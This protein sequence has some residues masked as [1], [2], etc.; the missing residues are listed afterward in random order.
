MAA[1]KKKTTKRKTTN[2]NKKSN[3]G[4][5]QSY[6]FKMCASLCV[7]AISVIAL[8]KL[9]IVGNFCFQFFSYFFG[10]VVYAVL[11][12]M[13][14][15]CLYVIIKKDISLIPKK[16]IFGLIFLLLGW[17]TL[18][19]II[20]T[21]PDP[22]W[23]NFSNVFENTFEILFDSMPVR[24]G[25]IGGLLLG[26]FGSLF[27]Y[28][29][30]YLVVGLFFVL[31]I[32]LFGYDYFI[33]REKK[34]KPKQKEK[35]KETKIE[36]VPIHEGKTDSVFVDVDN[37]FIDLEENKPSFQII[38]AD[39]PKPKKK[40]TSKKRA[41]KPKKEEKSIEEHIDSVPVSYVDTQEDPYV[42]YRLPRLS[43]LDSV[44]RKSRTSTNATVAKQQGQKLIDILYEYGVNAKLVQIHIGPSVTKFEIKPELGVRVSKIS[45][46]ANDIKMALAATDL[47]IEA[48]IPGKS[49]VG[50]EIPNVEKTPVQMKELMQS[51]P[52]EFDSKKLLFCLGKDL[53]GDN[54]YG[55]LNRMP[56]LLIA[57]ATG[58]GKSVCVNSIIC[59]LLLRTKP[60]EVKMILIDPKKVEFT[61]YNDVPHLLAPVITD[62][63]L[64]NKGLKVVVEMM[65]HRYDLF[66]NLG[67]RNIQA[68][69]EYVLNHPDEHLKPLPRLVVI[70]DE[71]ADLM[72]V[73]AKEVEA[74]IQRITQL[75]RA[76]G[77]H[78]VVATQRPS[79]DVITGVIKANIPSRIAFAVSQAV[80]S[81]TIL[82]QAGA[83]QLLGNGDMLYLPNGET[84]PKRIQ[85]VYIKDEEVNRICEY[86]KSQAKPH[87][88]DAFIQLK[89]LQNMGKEVAS[90]CADPLYEE[91]K[92]FVITSRRASTSLIQR[93][94]SI[95]YARAARLIDVLE[96]NRIIGPANGSKPR[97]ILV[98]NTLEDEE[99]YV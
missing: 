76:A 11:I 82:D 80:D 36:D 33:K 55:E 25:L 79:V 85:G 42:N 52:K 74:S 83:E 72:L 21:R 88:D 65:D 17:M 64:A 47:R 56:H 40:E 27:D 3:T 44:Q 23:S 75:A 94:F 8:C 43:I 96:E 63:D 5:M 19:A 89:D 53:T 68:Y 61:P 24:S 46:L 93:K 39:D 28:T 4:L 70:I 10:D 73:A 37:D 60:D 20:Q 9:G 51:I 13:I 2:K 92:R 7:I 54:V 16:Y 77:I 91:V 18:E 57:G 69:N 78:L 1:A 84:S 32:C 81:R 41:S 59:S 12:L 34:E 58:S 6:L 90:E 62:G 15:A 86:V 66:G 87:Y 29:G 49:A 98:Q 67:V 35:K 14:L 50:I 97:E 71:L 95:G 31:A 38:E 22:V 99:D 45:N 26:I 48:P 30:T